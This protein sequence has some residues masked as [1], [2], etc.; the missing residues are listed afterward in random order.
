VG[1]AF[2]IACGEGTLDEVAGFVSY[3]LGVQIV[4]EFPVLAD[5]Y[6]LSTGGE[7][8]AVALLTL[9][10]EETGGW[11]RIGDSL[12]QN[13]S[14]PGNYQTWAG[15]N[16]VLVYRDDRQS[17]INMVGGDTIQPSEEARQLRQE[18]ERAAAILNDIQNALHTTQ[19]KINL[20]QVCQVRTVAETLDAVS[21]I[22]G[23]RHTLQ[24]RTRESVTLA[25]VSC[26]EVGVPALLRFISTW[27]NT[28]I[29][30]G[31]AM[32]YLPLE[33]IPDWIKNSAPNGLYQYS[34]RADWIAVVGGELVNPDPNWASLFE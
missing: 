19:P 18:Y 26:G 20:S 25:S 6:A 11:V 32:P 24:D 17:L 21:Y 30:V 34:N 7:T 3:L 9:L 16:P 10:A 23:Y 4:T 12:P 15:Q 13:Y 31:D 33:A 28:S 29:A 2:E 22:T 14:P 8:D 1:F 27:L 5:P